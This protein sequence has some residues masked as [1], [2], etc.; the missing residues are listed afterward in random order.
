M[1]IAVQ[2]TFL[3]HDDPDESLARDPDTLAVKARNDDRYAGMRWLAADCA[4]QPGTS[5]SGLPVHF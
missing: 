3:P 5:V 1:G 2:W 4:H